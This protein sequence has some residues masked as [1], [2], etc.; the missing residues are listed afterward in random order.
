ME[1]LN[2][3][4][5]AGTEITLDDKR[6]HI[7]PLELDD[8]GLIEGMILK[9]RPNPISV[10]AECKDELPEDVWRELLNRA[11]TDARLVARATQEEFNDFTSSRNGQTYMLWLCIKHKHR[12]VTFEEIRDGINKVNDVEFKR[13]QRAIAIGTGMDEL[14]NSTGAPTETTTAAP[15]AETGGTSTDT[16]P[17]NTDGPP[18]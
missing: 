5:G 9:D 4:S 16:L 8:I 1:G 10:V 14:G 6:Y 18:A 13:L 7:T 3:A 12:D 2:R 17:K 15:S 11:Y